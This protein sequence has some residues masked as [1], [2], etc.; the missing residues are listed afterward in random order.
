MMSEQVDGRRFTRRFDYRNLY[1]STVMVIGMAQTGQAVTDLLLQQGAR[2]I[3]CDTDPSKRAALEE[4]YKGLPVRILLGPHEPVE[5]PDLI[6]LSPGVPCKGEFFDWIEKNRVPVLGELELASRFLTRPI[7]AVTGTNGKTTITGMIAHI[8]GQSGY[9]G[10]TAGNIG[11]P[12]SSFVTEHRARGPEPLVVEVSSFQLET[13]QHFRPKVAVI[14]NLAPDHLDRYAN[15]QDYYETKSLIA[16]NQVQEDC[17][18]IGPG[19][20]ELCY[21]ITDAT[22]QYFDISEHNEDGL[23]EVHGTVYQRLGASMEWVEIPGWKGTPIQQR[24]NAMAAVGAANSLGIPVSAGFKALQDYKPPRHRLEFIAFVHNI[25]CYNDS[26]ATNV[27][28]V[29]AAL[30]SVPAPIFMIAGGRYK[31]DPLDPLFPL[32]REKVRHI[33]LLGEAAAHFARALS[34]FTEVTIVRNMQEAVQKALTE[35][36]GPGSLLL[37]PACASWDMYQNYEERGDDYARAVEEAAR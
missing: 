10:E 32:V 29:C 21:P 6:V 34:P 37:S 11:K 22:I 7:V 9:V 23:Y 26:K 12:L 20:A 31:G 8:L 1:G 16:A 28:A 17:L 27:H 14:S 5:R 19:V 24:L 4:R 13:T 18:W 3:A 35:Q 33:Y 25:A 36:A 30:Q 2:V 15:I